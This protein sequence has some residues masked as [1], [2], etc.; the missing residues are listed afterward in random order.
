M[1]PLIRFKCSVGDERFEQILTYNRMLQWCD[2]DK[3][4]GEFFRL[5]SIQGHRKRANTAQG[6]LVKT[7]DLLPSRLLFRRLPV[8]PDN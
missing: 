3:D 2:Q 6:V 8:T 7:H 1:E 4:K 5:L